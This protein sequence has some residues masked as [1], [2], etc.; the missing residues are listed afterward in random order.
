VYWSGGLVLQTGFARELSLVDNT[1]GHTVQVAQS[2]HSV[3]IMYQFFASIPFHKHRNGN[4]NDID[5]TFFFL[6]FFCFVP[7]G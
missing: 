2:Q 3:G 1:G 4:D 6:F 7:V 5:I